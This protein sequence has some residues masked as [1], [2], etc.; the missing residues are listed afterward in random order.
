M[1]Q[2]R[3]FAEKT[4]LNPWMQPDL[5]L[6]KRLKDSDYAEDGPDKILEPK[7]L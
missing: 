7:G 1:S 5:V 4:P 2:S 3:V 6:C